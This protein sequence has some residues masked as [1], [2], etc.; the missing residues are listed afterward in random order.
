VPSVEHV[1]ASERLLDL[2]DFVGRC[3]DNGAGG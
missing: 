1:L 2:M 3:M